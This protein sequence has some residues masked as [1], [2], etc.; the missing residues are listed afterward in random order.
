MDNEPKLSHLNHLC[1]ALEV[2]YNPLSTP[3]E[4]AVLCKY[5]IWF[6]SHLERATPKPN[7]HG[8]SRELFEDWLTSGQKPILER[9]EIVERALQ[10]KTMEVSAT[11]A[12]D[13]ELATHIIILVMKQD[14]SGPS[15]ETDALQ[16]CF[17]YSEKSFFPENALQRR[18]DQMTYLLEIHRMPTSVPV[19]VDF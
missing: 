16:A 6:L 18:K 19:E 7:L 3:Q 13:A 10:A 1:N 14:G 4:E 17:R 5:F 9:W 12:G 2:A 8:T 11:Q 15:K